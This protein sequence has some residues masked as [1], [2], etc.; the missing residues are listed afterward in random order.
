VWL[1][2]AAELVSTVEEVKV[3]E[4]SL[5]VVLDGRPGFPAGGRDMVRTPCGLEGDGQNKTMLGPTKPPGSP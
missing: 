2:L 3:V 5:T 1:T 4:D